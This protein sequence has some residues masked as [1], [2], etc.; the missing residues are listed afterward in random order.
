MD[1]F[2]LKCIKHD[3]CLPYQKQ[4]ANLPLTP[5]IYPSSLLFV[6]DIYV[7]YA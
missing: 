2:I 5:S 7:L 3:Y 4:I 1:S 6:I